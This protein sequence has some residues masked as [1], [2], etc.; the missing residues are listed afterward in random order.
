MGLRTKLVKSHRLIK[1]LKMIDMFEII[2]FSSL[3]LFM[4]ECIRE[5]N[6]IIMTKI[7]IKT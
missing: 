1:W 2:F 7:C 6:V 5:R 3:Y 4:I